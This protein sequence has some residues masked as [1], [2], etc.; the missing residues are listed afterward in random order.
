[1]CEKANKTAQKYSKKK[2]IL[3]CIIHEWINVT[4]TTCSKDKVTLDDY[5]K[6]LTRN[7]VARSEKDK[8]KENAM[9]G[10]R[11]VSTM[12][13]R[14]VKLSPQ[15]STSTLCYKTKLYCHNFNVQFDFKKSGLVL[16][17]RD[18]SWWTGLHLCLLFGALL[19]RKL[20]EKQ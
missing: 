2:W 6:H 9:N 7:N 11:H 14:T 5:E 13:V 10:K 15:I 16:D 1:M 12:D 8:E 20:F 17:Y 18:R 4:F 3:H 19:R